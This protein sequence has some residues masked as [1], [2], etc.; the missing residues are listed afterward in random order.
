[1]IEVVVKEIVGRG[2]DRERYSILKSSRV[3]S[4]AEW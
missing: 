2:R 4:R 1:V 3:K